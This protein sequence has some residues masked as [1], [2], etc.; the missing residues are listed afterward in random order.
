MSTRKLLT[1][2]TVGIFTW[3]VVFLAVRYN[4][5]SVYERM[6]HGVYTKTYEDCCDPN[7]KYYTCV[8]SYYDEDGR[9]YTTEE[10][11]ELNKRGRQL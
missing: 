7:N 9:A 3:V 2:I 11:K 6:W 1:I 4:P 5:L 10:L 8:E